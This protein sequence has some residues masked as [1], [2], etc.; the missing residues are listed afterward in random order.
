M[1]PFP[2][3]GLAELRDKYTY[4]ITP[5]TQSVSSVARRGLRLFYQEDEEEQEL[6]ADTDEVDPD[7]HKIAMATA[8]GFSGIF[9]KS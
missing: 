1:A 6:D 4:N 5:W 7:A 2:F 9:K 8:F 3:P